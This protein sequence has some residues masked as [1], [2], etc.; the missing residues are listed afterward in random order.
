MKLGAAYLSGLQSRT[1]Y[2][3]ARQIVAVGLLLYHFF[4]SDWPKPLAAA[5]SVANTISLTLAASA[6][7]SP[8]VSELQVVAGHDGV[9]RHLKQVEG[10]QVG[11][12]LDCQQQP[13]EFFQV[14]GARR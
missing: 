2:R 8:A 1:T 7:A 3:L 13:L 10:G 12:V 11:V 9:V 14:M 4:Q 6:S 5:A